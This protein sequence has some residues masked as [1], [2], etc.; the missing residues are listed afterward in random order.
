MP[1]VS[2]Y[3]A[4][5]SGSYWNGIEVTGKPVI[6]TYSFPTAA[7]DYVAATGGFTADTVASYLAFN[8]AEQA[9][10]R[11]ALGEWAAASGITFIEVAPGKGDINFQLVDFDTT[12]GPSYA[13]A[14]GIG[15]YPFGDWNF[16]T[17]PSFSSDLDL[18]GDI[19]MNSQ[20]AGGGTVNYGTL[21]HEIG[22]AIG[23]KHPTE[24]VTDFAANPV[25]VHDQVLASDD[26][27]LTVM[28]TVGDSTPPGSVHLHQLDQDAAAF[29][30]GAAGTGGVVTGSASGANAV[31]SWSWDAAAQVLSQTGFAG[32][33]VI[34]GSS[35]EDIING[36]GGDNR[37]FGLAGDDHLTAGS[38]HDFLDGGP[39]TDTMTGGAGD[40][41]YVVDS[42]SDAVVEA[43]GGGSDSVLAS[44]SYTLAANVELL[45][46][47]GAGLTGQGNGLAN[48]L[49]GDGTLAD[50]LSGL[51]GN[52]YIVAGAG[53]DTLYGG[54]GNDSL[55]GGAGDDLIEGGA[56][57]DYLV[58]GDGVDTASYAGAT[59]RVVASLAL[60]AAQGTLGAGTDTLAGF[61]NLAG[62]AYN[63][64]LTGDSGANILS[65][66]AG[67]D[68]LSGGDGIDTL[69]GGEGDDTLNDVSTGG[70]TLDGG[71]GTDIASFA[72][73]VAAVQVTVEAGT[74]TQNSG[75]AG[76]VTLTSI[77]GLIGS[78]FGDYLSGDDAANSLYGGLGDDVLDGRGGN[79][80][81]DG[82]SG[83]D[84]VYYNHSTAGVTVNLLST[85]AQNTGGGG[86]D[87][88][89][90]VENIYATDW[91]DTLTGNGFGN[92]LVGAGGD[93]VLNGGLGNDILNGDVGNDT[94]TYANA[95]GGVK[96]SLLVTG[97]QSTLSAG[98]DQL[99][100]IENLTGSAFD[101]QLT[102][103]GGDNVLL[104]NGG[105]DILLG[106]LGNDLL[107][108][109]S[110]SD[111]TSYAGLAT[112]VSVNLLLTSA[113]N[114]GGGGIDTFVSIE[115]VTG[116]SFDDVLTGNAQANSLSGG[117]GNDAIDGGSSNDVIDGGAGNDML[118]G[119]NA[120]DVL[121]GGSGTDS[122]DGG[123]GID[124][125]SYAAASA[126]VTVSLALATAQAVG[127]GQGTDTILNVEN[128]LGSAFADTLTGSALAN[129]IT[130]GA[131]KDFLTG[132][133]GNDSFVFTA[134]TDSVPGANA[135]R[136][137]DFAAG[138]ILD[139]S[140]ID[141][142]TTSPGTDEAFHLA[143]GFTHHAGE[144][145]L[146]YDAGS[147]TTT[148]LADTNGDTSADMSILFTGDVTGLTGTWL[149]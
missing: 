3:T 31:S 21:L 33:D 90:N 84:V 70:N 29:L 142:D 42:A 13:G 115:N 51:A 45:Q 18:S 44:V 117:S 23:L 63:D 104:G 67:N 19:F 35:V 109:G 11:A 133:A 120:D 145:T 129:T 36:L 7:P 98:T 69:Y 6:V 127:G 95:T 134:L 113:Q 105:N 15:F 100:G 106:G 86:I 27:S 143:A 87:T 147:N 141:A 91:N 59:A 102:G 49:Y 101:D 79:D 26:P 138:D 55:F 137:T 62:S 16:F 78:N 54:D 25:V 2:D 1:E 47:F 60:T 37:L 88:L 73:A 8:P 34:R 39:G 148:L 149:F 132:G 17:Y 22:H 83:T 126:G 96:V 14:G 32:D 112:A 85:S 72:G 124:T 116:S 30:Y 46:L 56:G 38:G 107:N 50:T 118:K 119:G 75:G 48:T 5:L 92:T 71:A 122:I 12:S 64:M 81:I 128:L 144:V 114:T 76:S 135:D 4:L 89:R 111:T 53:A 74:S 20:F 43:A 61:E 40:D 68:I 41:T 52:D 97:F 9:Q 80:L 139:L 103:D 125:V 28:A 58:G 57:T 77:E 121:I 136:I 131:G 94:A 140:R 10:A 123:S 108:G 82:G 110:G 66:A 146:A 130:G 65:G 99:I 24:T 93:D